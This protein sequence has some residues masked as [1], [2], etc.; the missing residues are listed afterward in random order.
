[1]GIYKR[2]IFGIGTGPGDPDL[3][4]LKAIRRLRESELIFAP[5]SRG[6][7]LALDTALDYVEDKKIQLLSFPMGEVAEEDY[8]SAAAAIEKAC[9]QL[10]MA[11]PQKL[12]KAAVL[13]LG[14]PLIYSTF[15]HLLP[16]F[17]DDSE[18]EI[19]S[20]I[21]AFLSAA[22]EAQIPLCQG[23]HG[24][25]VQDRW[26][27]NDMA[28]NNLVLLKSSRFQQSDLEDMQSKGYRMTR[29]SRASLPEQKITRDFAELESKEDYLSLLI[30]EK[31]GDESGE[32]EP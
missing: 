9:D 28:E 12:P 3:L 19:V 23:S 24:L 6:K 2:K 4:T 7:H 27:L 30:L 1:M 8:R 18:I 14:D 20:G 31:R 25:L 29:V 5:T 16:Y 11:D 13:T 21:P 10:R 22:A 32:L 26:P 15:A 17:Q